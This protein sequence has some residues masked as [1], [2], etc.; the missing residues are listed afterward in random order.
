LI[1]T[2]WDVVLGFVLLWST[3]GWTATRHLMSREGRGRATPD[4]REE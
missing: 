3:I 4:A 1:L 2:A